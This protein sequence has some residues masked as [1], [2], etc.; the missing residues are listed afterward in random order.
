LLADG[1]LRLTQLEER[2]ESMQ[3]DAAAVISEY[4]EVRSALDSVRYQ[5]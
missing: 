2:R 1:R 3:G 4:S 5:L